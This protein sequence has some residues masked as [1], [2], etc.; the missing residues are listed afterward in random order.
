[1]ALDLPR[2]KSINDYA[3]PQYSGWTYLAA[4]PA[5]RL[6]LISDCPGVSQGVHGTVIQVLFVPKQVM[7]NRHATTIAPSIQLDSSATRLATLSGY[8]NVGP[9]YPPLSTLRGGCSVRISLLTN[10][11][12]WWDRPWQTTHVTSLPMWLAEWASSS[13]QSWQHPTPNKQVVLI[14]EWWLSYPLQPSHPSAHRFI[15]SSFPTEQSFIQ[16]RISKAH[17]RGILL[18]ISKEFCSCCILVY[19][20]SLTHPTSVTNIDSTS[21]KLLKTFRCLE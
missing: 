13:P 21:Q 16:I 17:W 14:H 12:G 7:K 19:W 1:M 6:S 2:L 18:L 5:H 4:V 9:I 15:W 11:C 20:L 3:T 10:W 8:M